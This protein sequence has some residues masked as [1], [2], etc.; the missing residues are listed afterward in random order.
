MGVLSFFSPA[1]QK[2][3]DKQPFAHSGVDLSCLQRG[4]V[5]TNERKLKFQ[6]LK[7]KQIPVCTICDR[8]FSYIST[9]RRHMTSVHSDASVVCPDCRESFTTAA[10]LASHRREV[11]AISPQPG[12]DLSCTQCGQQCANKKALNAH[13]LIHD[14]K[15]VCMVCNQKFAVRY[16][17]HCHKILQHGGESLVEP[18]DCPECGKSFSN[19]LRMKLHRSGTHQQSRSK[20]HRCVVCNAKFRND[21]FLDAH[22]RRAHKD[23]QELKC[24]HCVETFETL[25][26]L[27]EHARVHDKRFECRL[28]SR[29]FPDGSE[30]K[31]HTL[32]EHEIRP[33]ICNVCGKTYRINL[34][35]KEHM[36]IHTG[37]RPFKCTMCEKSFVQS[38]NLTNHFRIHTGERSHICNV[39][40]KNYARSIML[41]YHQ[42]IHTGERPHTCDV[43]HKSFTSPSMLSTHKKIHSKQKFY[44]CEE[45]DAKFNVKNGLNRHMRIH[46]GVKKHVCRFCG[47]GFNQGSNLRT[48]M[49]IHTRERPY[50]CNVCE[51]SFPHHGTWKKH[52]ETHQKLISVQ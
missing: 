15:H 1:M 45:C 35:L 38:S 12:D 31:K 47:N 8:K 10:L 37:D 40:G 34:C 11:H 51:Q 25:T 14:K 26:S 44:R 24:F 39:C 22:I 20:H 32:A 23:Q 50:K 21:F 19:E 5:F 29:R 52:I 2:S 33:F 17:L 3:S 16:A 42:R 9:H 30:L 4:N 46:S 36:R 41:K 27:H 28:C 43:C 49:R 13:V 6:V 7:H 48:H 18:V